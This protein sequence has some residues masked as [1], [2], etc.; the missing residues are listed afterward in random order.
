[1]HRARAA[2]PR[3]FDSLPS[4]ALELYSPKQTST[5]YHTS[6]SKKVQYLP[7]IREAKSHNLFFRNGT[8]LNFSTR[9]T[10]V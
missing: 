4:N 8:V 6:T 9:G 7:S 3:G 2:R 1:M 10:A 5:Y